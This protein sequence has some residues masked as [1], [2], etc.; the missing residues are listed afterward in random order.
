MVELR[1]VPVRRKFSIYNHEF[2]SPIPF[3]PLS[4][5]LMDEV[6][7]AKQNI[8][9]ETDFTF[10]NNDP[11]S[12]EIIQSN[13]IEAIETV[14]EKLRY[15]KLSKDQYLMKTTT[16]VNYRNNMKTNYCVSCR[17]IYTTPYFLELHI[18]EMHD[19]FFQCSSLKKP[20]YNCMVYHCPELFW[21]H[22]TRLQHLFNTHLY[23][24][25]FHMEISTNIYTKF[26]PL[27][28]HSKSK[29]NNHK[30]TPFYEKAKFKS[31][32]K[33]DEEIEKF[34]SKSRT[35]KSN[36]SNKNDTVDDVDMEVT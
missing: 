26:N 11:K 8:D 1:L 23:P 19:S 24:K 20:S 32:I 22:K 9:M 6:S 10:D 4:R 17:K 25:S 35:I 5:T 7:D 2:E 31:K 34:D 14:D 21:N 27:N 33:L 15:K 30:K 16:S 28:S 36:K 18:R 3:E 12:E 29:I 13:K